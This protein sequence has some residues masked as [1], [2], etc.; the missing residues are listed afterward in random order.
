MA[1]RTDRRIREAAGL[2]ERNVLPDRKHGGDRRV[3]A[4]E[5]TGVDGDHERSGRGGAPPERARAAA[6][7][8][9]ATTAIRRMGVIGCYRSNMR[10]A[11]PWRSFLA[12]SLS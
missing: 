10:W 5:V 6:S 2:V 11:L 9:A 1:Q 4:R 12:T 8:T 3:M 7:S